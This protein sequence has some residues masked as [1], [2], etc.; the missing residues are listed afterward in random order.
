MEDLNLYTNDEG[1]LTVEWTLLKQLKYGAIMLAGF[2]I[3]CGW[4]QFT[5]YL[6]DFAR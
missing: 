4:F 2:G 5:L 3:V 1:E 6:M